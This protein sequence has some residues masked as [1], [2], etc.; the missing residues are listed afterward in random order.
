MGG[1]VQRLVCWSVTPETL[2]SIP[3]P[4]PHATITEMNMHAQTLT[5]N[6]SYAPCGVVPWQQA[7]TL[8][9]LGKAEVLETYDDE[10]H[11][12]HLVFKVPAV[13]RLLRK[14]RRDK[15]RVKFSRVNVCARDDFRCMYCGTKKAIGELSY[16]HVVP[17]SRG[18][19][20]EW[21]NIVA[22]CYDCNRKKA[23]R[24]PAEAGMKLRKQPVQP[25]STPAVVLRV[26][27]ENAP[28]AWRDYLYWTG[29]LETDEPA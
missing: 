14:F 27:R 17:K 22:A 5:L 6:M 19:K 28:A 20:T 25:T 29:D 24:T 2:G 1:F 23:N 15:K 8:V 16:D 12:T 21:K 13:I 26:S 11:S 10:V 3:A 18:G 7:L 9:F 4:S